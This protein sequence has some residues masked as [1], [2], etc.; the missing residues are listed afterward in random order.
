MSHGFTSNLAGVPPATLQQWLVDAQTAL[1]LLSIGGKPE[2]VAYAQADGSKSVTY[3]RANLA[4]LQAHIV[5]L[6]A[7]LGLRSRSRRA[8]TPFF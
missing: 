6:Q 8:I 4:Q 7:A 3:T 2:T 5:A 1:H